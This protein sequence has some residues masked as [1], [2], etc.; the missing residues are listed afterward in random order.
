MGDR[1]AAVQFYNTAITALGDK[2]TNPGAVNHAYQLF[3]SACLVDPTWHESLFQAGNNCS[4]LEYKEAAVACYR[5]ALECKMTNK[6]RCKVYTNLGWKLH[7][8]GHTREALKHSLHAIKLD[9]TEP[10][11][12][13]N[14]SCIYQV[15]CDTRESLYY[16]QEALKI[17]PDN[18]TVKTAHA[19]ALL[20]DRKLAS[21]L[22][23]F[24]SRF[25]YELKNFTQFPYPRWQGEEGKTIYLISDQG[26]GDTLSYARFLREVCKRSKYVH[27]YVHDPLMRAFAHAFVDIPNLNL[28]PTS[29][30]FM[31]ADYWTTFVSL[32]FALGL[33]DEE[34]RA[35]PPVDIPIHSVPR[36]WLVPDR[37][38]HVGI[39]WAGSPLNKIDSHR[40][41]PVQMFGELFR[42]PGVQ[43]YSLQIGDKAREMHDAGFSAVIRDIAPYVRDVVDTVA[44]MQHLD[45][46]IGIESAL[47][48]ICA[49]IG[50]EYW[51]PYSRWGK[52]YRVGVDGKDPIWT[53][54]HRFFLQYEHEL[55]WRPVFM[56]IADALEERVAGKAQSELELVV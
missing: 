54:R 17:D 46:V 48:H 37:R 6:E 3:A 8:L 51:M 38:L 53:P 20:F 30:P 21:G 1:H 16:A 50:K 19:F 9:Q 28:T 25:A 5:R 18:A 55:T 13:V 43:L 41:V 35:A 31:P 23:A 44:L 32:P 42:V 45:L 52:D 56:R 24:E 2:A 26:L 4:D 15:M 11:S 34:I 40:N 22:K 36:N 7:Q 27:A 49:A 39:C 47:G 33:T 12:F 10:F 29:T 14:L